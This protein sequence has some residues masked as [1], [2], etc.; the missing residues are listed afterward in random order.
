MDK[1]IQILLST[2][3]GE[4]YLREQLDS[5]LALDNYGEAKVLVRDDG[6]TDGTP[7][8][9]AEYAERHGFEIIRGE[10]M[11]FVVSMFELFRHSDPACAYF[12]T[13]DQDDVW[14]PDKLSAGIRALEKLPADMPLLYGSATQPVT[15]NL[16]LVGKPFTAPRGVSFY[17]AMVQNVVPGHTQILNRPLVDVLLS[18]D[19][20]HATV[21][22]WW[23]YLLASGVG[24]VIYDAKPRVFYRQHGSNAI[25]SETSKTRLWRGRAKRI[26]ENRL[27]MATR[28][29][30]DF[31][32]LYGGK[33]SQKMYFQELQGFL[34][35]AVFFTRLRYIM[36]AK[37][38]RQIAVETLCV[39]LLFLFG[40]YKPNDGV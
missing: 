21:I 9:L 37:V 34:N 18:G 24:Q 23:I 39:K 29:L 5:F 20:R 13:S 7:Q 11:G 33:L 22:D 31:L 6:S 35:Q 40:Q 28:Q 16:T 12:A 8:I 4:R 25:G 1:K 14:L 17:N 27:S 19:V 32:K 15:E 2:H 38:F 36:K 30:Q 26:L 3:N 10:N